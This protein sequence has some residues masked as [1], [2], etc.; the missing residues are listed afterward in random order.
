MTTAAIQNTIVHS[1]EDMHLGLNKVAELMKS[2]YAKNGFNGDYEIEFDFGKKYIKV[3]VEN[4]GS[5]SVNG[6]VVNCHNDK[7][8]PY[9]TLLKAAGWK[10]PARNKSRG[11]VFELEGK[12]LP[13]TGI[14]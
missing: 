1:K 8:F 12:T 13:W 2:D 3:V 9:G 10:A 14:E 5:R 11:S 4:R 7:E 6:F